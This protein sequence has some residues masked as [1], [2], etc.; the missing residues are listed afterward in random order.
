QAIGLD[1]ALAAS[2][3]GRAEVAVG[4]VADLAIVDVDPYE[5]D[6]ET[7]RAM[8]VSGT[9]LGGRWT[10]CALDRR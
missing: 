6:A 1:V 10:W 3:G 9:L 7:L 5:A 2:T 4:D 8:P